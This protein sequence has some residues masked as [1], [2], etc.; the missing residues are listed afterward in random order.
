[1]ARR[2]I[3]KV[4]PPQIADREEADGSATTTPVHTTWGNLPL[5]LSSFV[6]RE[7]EISEVEGV[8]GGTRLLTLTGTGGCG[9]TRL[10]LRVAKDLAE[11]FDD[12]VWWVGLAPLADPDL[13]PNSVASSLGVHEQQG[14]SMVEALS[15]HLRSRDLMLILDNCEHLIGACAGLVETLLLSC[16]DLKILATSRESL[17][18][19]GE[20]VWTVPTLSLPEAD[21]TPTVEDLMRC[22]AVRL[23]V[24]RAR[25]RLPAF[26]VS[27]EN[28]G[29]V[30]RV[31]RMLDGIPLAI[32][33][34]SA[35][36]G[37]LAVGQVAERLEDSLGFLTVG[38]RTV[39]A[40]HRTMRA[41]LRWSHELLSA[42]EQR[43]FAKLSVFAGGWTLEAA[44]EVCRDGAAGRDDVLDFLGRLVD[45]SLVSA[46]EKVDD[47]ARYRMLEPVRQY[48]R[49][50]LEENGEGEQVRQRH[51]RYYLALAEAAE[52]ELV[53]AGHAVWLERLET[54]YPNLH[55]SLLWCL[56]EEGA[57][58][59]GRAEMGLRLA[60]ALGKF[61]DVHGPSEG[62]EW[63]EKGLA[64]SRAAPSSLRAKA[65]NEAGFLAIFQL[66]SRAT[67]MLEEALAL[68]KDLGDKT[69]QAIAINHLMYTVGFLIDF[70]EAVTIREEAQALLKQ[71]PEDQRAA[72]NLH[73]T[74]GMI[75]FGEENHEQ[76]VVQIEE[77][78]S[79]FR[80]LGDL[81]NTGRG[82]SVLGLAALGRGDAE[83]AARAYDEFLRLLLLLKSKIGATFAL[84][85]MAGVAVLRG[86]PHR[87][88]SLFGAADAARK[89]IGHPDPPL[90][91]LNYDYE[92]Y[93]ATTRTALGEEAFEE[94][95]CAGLAMSAEQAIKYALSP[96]EPASITQVS[97]Q[98][99]GGEVLTRREV[100][101]LS[102]VAGGLTDVQIAKRLH[103]S[104]HTVGH[105]LSSVY[106]KLG[107]K[108][109][110]AAVHKAGELGLI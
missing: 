34:A 1:M 91:Q 77:A 7:R 18:V 82:L 73:L 47:A 41:T 93:I 56:D 55:A 88:A 99:P 5:E 94:A 96:D 50:H 48:G 101:V 86:Q 25:S 98:A 9:K 90:K 42:P 21:G 44:E 109:R 15:D 105:H 24:D 45:K 27:Q 8:L 43:L 2:R 75:A 52:R 74:L 62:R 16:P 39:D 110:A 107:A 46:E 60:A 6:G 53:G 11:K 70:S 92:S 79:L 97:E 100:E 76:V 19:P 64:K 78:L 38:S 29:M 71:P 102:F 95:F 54:E 30:A 4:R 28:V 84:I 106:R 33:L 32:E 3:A 83:D 68:F 63:L 20:T 81:L 35:R 103:L 36:M 13:T 49:E 80:K 10:A 26:E 12:G 85:G 57:K 67:A 104:R 89:A 17:G 40:R 69:G 87:A 31:C 14:R 108:G 51:A 66:D 65:L 72:A 58:P 61:W 23:F 22:E 37:T 59:E